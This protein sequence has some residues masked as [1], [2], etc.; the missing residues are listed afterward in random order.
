MIA[1]IMVILFLTGILFGML[2]VKLSNNWVEIHQID[3]DNFVYFDGETYI[4]TRIKNEK[5]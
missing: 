5:Q 2:L 1:L 3:N 4:L